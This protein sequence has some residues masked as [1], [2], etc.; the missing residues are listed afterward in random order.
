[1]NNSASVPNESRAPRRFQLGMKD[2]T[3]LVAVSG[4]LAWAGWRIW[5]N[6][7]KGEETYVFQETLQRLQSAEASERW[8]AAGNLHV[9]NHRDEIEPAI[10][11]LVRALNDEDPQVKDTSARS[12]GALVRRLRI[13][14]SSDVIVEPELVRKI[15][16][17]AT[18]ALAKSLS[19]PAQ[20]VRVGAAVGIGMLST[21]PSSASSGGGMA[22]PMKKAGAETTN[23]PSWKPPRDLAESLRTG[24]KKWNRETAQAY[25]GYIASP[26]PPALV[27]ALQDPSADVRAQAVRSL[28]NYPLDLDSA[29]PALLS[30][31]EKDDAEVR[32]IAADVLRKAWPTAVVVPNLAAA[33]KSGD[34]NVRAPAV[35]LLGRIGP[36]ASSAVPALLEI[37]IETLESNDDALVTGAAK[38]LAKF[39]REAAPAVPK[40]RALKD[41]GKSESSEAAAAALE[42]I[43]GRSKTK[44]ETSPSN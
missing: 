6:F 17:R 33:L 34:A 41:R 38:A 10:A 15:T 21:Q 14:S 35:L 1:M 12:L 4:L 37:L 24:E 29:I 32:S 43:E 7:N 27:A 44:D 42:V 39:G 26:P 9:V 3:I 28:E 22:S 25:F 19:D 8:R 20:N 30:M 16:E 23:T 5:D 31:L 11:A 36:D 13:P 2:L 18:T 40:L